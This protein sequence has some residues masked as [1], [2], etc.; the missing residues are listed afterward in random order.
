MGLAEGTKPQVF[1]FNCFAFDVT[2]EASSLFM[3][4]D[5]RDCIA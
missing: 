1:Q 3:N 4:H 2:G 5:M